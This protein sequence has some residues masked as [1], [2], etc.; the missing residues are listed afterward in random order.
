[1]CDTCNSRDVLL[2]KYEQNVTKSEAERSVLEVQLRVARESI[3]MWKNLYR[4]AAKR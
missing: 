2:R 3:E 1:M 4:D